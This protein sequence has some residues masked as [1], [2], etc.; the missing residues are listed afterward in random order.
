[1]ESLTLLRDSSI[2]ESHDVVDILFQ[3]FNMA[4]QEDL[5]EVLREFRLE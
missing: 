2:L 3:S 4:D 5:L 1:M